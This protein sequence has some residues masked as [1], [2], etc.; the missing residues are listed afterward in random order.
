MMYHRR[1]I[2]HLCFQ[3]RKV[4]R[5]AQ[6]PVIYGRCK[7]ITMNERSTLTQH[8]TIVEA[9]SPFDGD[10]DWDDASWAARNDPERLRAILD[11]RARPR[12]E[13]QDE[14]DQYSDA[15]RKL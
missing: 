8:I 7:E 1:H 9:S 6:H 2:Q 13:K 12:N 14:R 5:M 3:V 4:A 15:L 10:W 11:E